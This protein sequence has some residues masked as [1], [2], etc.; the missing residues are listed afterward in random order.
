MLDRDDPFEQSYDE[1][2]FQIF[3]QPDD[4]SNLFRQLEMKQKDIQHSI[5]NEQSQK[6]MADEQAR[7]NI[8]DMLNFDDIEDRKD[9]P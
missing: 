2:K 9:E 3:T 1:S 8:L 5:L 6:Q 7:K 4:K